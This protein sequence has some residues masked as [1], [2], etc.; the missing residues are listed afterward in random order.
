[1][2]QLRETDIKRLMRAYRRGHP[3]RHRIVALCQSVE[4]PVNVGSVFRLADALDLEEVI[5]TGITPTPP[6]AALSKA[7]RGK[8][9]RVPWRYVETPGEVIPELKADGFLVCAVEITDTAVPYM[10]F[11]YPERVCLVVGHED[12]GVTNQTLALCDRSVYIPMFGK[13]RSLNV[14]VSLSIVCAHL[15][16]GCS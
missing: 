15:R 4:Y 11:E 10:D 2:K 8:E 16:F 14:H 3:P 12:H 6:N 7:S 1:M 9:S 13:G 5:L